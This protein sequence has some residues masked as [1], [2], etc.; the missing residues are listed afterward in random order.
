ME[1]FKI[2]VS[3]LRVGNYVKTPSGIIR[4]EDAAQMGFVAA[5]GCYGIEV[6]PDILTKNFSYD[7]RTWSNRQILYDFGFRFKTDGLRMVHIEHLTTS[8]SAPIKYVHQLQNIIFAITGA[9][10]NLSLHEEDEA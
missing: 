2:P 3:H 4:L 6:T 5:Q 7:N 10:L 1:E 8:Y 9:E